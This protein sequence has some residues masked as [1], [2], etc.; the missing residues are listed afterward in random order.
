LTLLH[1]MRISDGCRCPG[2]AS[3]I[4]DGLYFLPPAAC[5]GSGLIASFDMLNFSHDDSPTASL[6]LDRATIESL[7][8]PAVP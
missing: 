3:V 6:I 1:E 5:V 8:P 4:Y 7:S 2:T